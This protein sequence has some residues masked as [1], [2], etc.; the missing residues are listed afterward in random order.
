[1]IEL[2]SRIWEY[3]DAFENFPFFHLDPLPTVPPEDDPPNAAAISDSESDSNSKNDRQVR[4][5]PS[6]TVGGADRALK[7]MRLAGRTL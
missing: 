2:K 5:S 6:P 1:M 7:T 3:M 4:P